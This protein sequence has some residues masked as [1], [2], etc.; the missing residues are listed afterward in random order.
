MDMVKVFIIGTSRE[1][2]NSQHFTITHLLDLPSDYIPIIPTQ[3]AHG[4]YEED[5]LP[6]SADKLSEDEF[7]NRPD[8]IP[9]G[10]VTVLI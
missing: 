7:S 9:G 8:P 1:K 2:S 5:S 4:Y 10:L 3:D 6:S